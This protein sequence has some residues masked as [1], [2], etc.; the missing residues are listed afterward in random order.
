MRPTARQRPWSFLPSGAKIAWPMQL[1]ALLL[2]LLLSALPAQSPQSFSNIFIFGD[3]LS[4]DGNLFSLAGIPAAPYWEGRFS[5]GPVWVEQL[6]RE[7]GLDPAATKNFAIGGSTT[8]LVVESQIPLALFLNVRRFP[9]EA[10]YVF[11]AGTNDM[12]GLLDGVGDPGQIILD[13][14]AQTSSALMSMA[15][16]GAIT[17]LVP[18]LPDLSRLP[19]SLQNLSKPEIAAIDASVREYNAALALTLA[20]LEALLGL[21]IIALDTYK[22]TAQ[23]IDDP[24]TF[25]LKKVSESVIK[26]D[27]RLVKKPADYLFFDDIHP[28]AVGHRLIMRAV[29][30]AL[31]RE[32]RG[33]LNNDDIVNR[34]DLKLLRKSYGPCKVACAADLNGDGRVDREDA[35]ILTRILQA[36]VE[37]GRAEPTSRIRPQAGMRAMPFPR[38]D[39][40]PAP[41]SSEG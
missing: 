40:G 2:P 24:K 22:L 9:P 35:K 37:G 21:E 28:T 29:L 30:T 32:I 39:A 14:M 34:D 5:N 4:D 1:S 26:K 20:Q 13:A 8:S 41:A 25:M 15:N 7:I 23:V 38:R 11:W 10:L 36:P 27:G 12:L 3:S 18:N 6:A 31:G 33:D 19:R 16:A 17:V